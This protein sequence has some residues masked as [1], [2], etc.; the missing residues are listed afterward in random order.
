VL[1][2]SGDAYYQQFEVAVDADFLGIVLDH[3]P[4]SDAPMLD[5]ARLREHEEFLKQLRKYLTGNNTIK[6]HEFLLNKRDLWEKDPSKTQLLDWFNQQVEEW[7]GAFQGTNV[8][9]RPFSNRITEDG[10]SFLE[11]VARAAGGR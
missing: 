11:R 10:P 5:Q 1:D 8:D 6:N 9:S 7:R 2:G 4:H 3:N